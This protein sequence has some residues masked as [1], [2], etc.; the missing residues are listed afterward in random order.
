[1]SPRAKLSQHPWTHPLRR[2]RTYHVAGLDTPAATCLRTAY[3][4]ALHANRTDV[5]RAHAADA[6]ITDIKRLATAWGVD[7]GEG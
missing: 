2:A 4:M 1:M 3:Q 6:V 7:L 5:P